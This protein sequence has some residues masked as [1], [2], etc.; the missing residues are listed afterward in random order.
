[1]PLEG[2]S[3]AHRL[4]FVRETTLGLPNVDPT[5]LLFS[6]V[7]RRFNASPGHSIGILRGV[8]DAD[9]HEFN[10][11]KEEPT[12][13]H[14]Y[15]LQ[16]AL[17]SDAANDGLT[18][19][20]DN[21]LPNSH[22]IVER[23]LHTT[24]G[25]DADAGRR[26][27]QVTEGAKIG[28]AS[29]RGASTDEPAK[30]LVTLDYR[31]EKTREYR[32]D[33]PDAT[34]TITIVSSDAADTTQTLT[35]EDD[36]A[37]VTEG[38]S[39]NGVTPVIGIVMFPTL[40]ALRLDL[41]TKGDITI[42]RTTGGAILAVIRGR[43]FY[44]GT[45]GDLGIPLLGSGAHASAFGTA[46]EHFFGD[47]VQYG[48]VDV[49]E[50]IS[51][52]ELIV[53]NNLVV[54]PLNTRRVRVAEGDRDVDLVVQVFGSSESFV[55]MDRNLGAVQANLAWQLDSTL[56]TLLN[57]ALVQPGERNLEQGQ[58]LMELSNRFR[59]TGLTLA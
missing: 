29:V 16:Q 57:A 4:E 31:P 38:I 9:P 47:T 12:Q 42:T 40:D 51:V 44:D 18:R 1:M 23:E 2:A 10:A 7:F 14:Q 36:G 32:V 28:R 37:A 24:G 25:A 15:Y 33:Q 50:N 56:V 6:D 11:G 58:A 8:G 53:E 30:I 49:G 41:E 17:G 19:N 46:F 55:T 5:W 3:R 59:G 27:Y 34:D 48:G 26:L 45:V 39:L 52:S 22:H 35:A 20:A 43:D 54:Q 13:Q 21:A